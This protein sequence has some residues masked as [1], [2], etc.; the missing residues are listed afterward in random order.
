VLSDFPLADILQN[1]DAKYEALLHRLR[2]AISLG[3][4]RLLIYDDS[5][6]VV[7]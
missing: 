2:L 1:Q 5:L 7:Q 4:K 6:L 3:I